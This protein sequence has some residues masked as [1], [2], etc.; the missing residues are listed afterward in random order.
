MDVDDTHHT[1]ECYSA[2]VAG[3][4]SP[5]QKSRA[6]TGS[7]KSAAWMGGSEQEVTEVEKEAVNKSHER[8]MEGQG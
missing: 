5:N 4:A 6:P 7:A 8:Q 1:R 3:E 2:G